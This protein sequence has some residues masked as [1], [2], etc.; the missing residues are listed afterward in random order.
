MTRFIKIGK[1]YINMDRI[2]IIRQCAG[3]VIEVVLRDGR[4]LYGSLQDLK[5]MEIIERP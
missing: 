4:L 2:D 5:R 3:N 1:Y